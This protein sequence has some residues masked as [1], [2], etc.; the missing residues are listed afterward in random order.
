[1][2]GVWVALV[3]ATAGCNAFDP[4]VLAPL[5]S[6]SPP[7][8]RPAGADGGLDAKTH[9]PPNERDADA[10]R[11]DLDGSLGGDGDA[12]G[13][14]DGLDAAVSDASLR[15]ARSDD[16]SDPDGAACVGAST[17]DYCAALPQ[18]LAPPLIDGALD[19]GPPLLPLE[20]TAWN[21]AAPIPTGHTAQLALG[22]R[23]DGLYA[24]LEVRG[25]TPVPHPSGSAIYC[26]DAIE[27]YVDADG[28]IASDGAYD[29]PGTMQ[30]IFA[31]PASELAPNPHAERFVAGASQGV[32]TSSEHRIAWLADGYAVEAFIT[33]ADLGLT[34]WMPA[35]ALG[36]DVVIDVSGPE[37][38]ELRCGR[39]LGQYFLRVSSLTP[40]DCNG[41][42]WCDAR[43]FCTP[44]LPQA[45]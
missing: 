25:Q 35:T 27:L 18:L 29:Q 24:Y 12:D 31:A 1:M 42:P 34:S 11:P 40:S 20:P 28:A 37:G 22:Y 45:Q 7:N 39:Q 13:D 36:L 44:S 14:G 6:L 15:D 33:A 2:P 10:P 30:L 4:D 38:A 32:W 23:H 17:N 21:G 8:E 3:C 16:A 5:A 9:E 43:A 19:C 26:G 41:E